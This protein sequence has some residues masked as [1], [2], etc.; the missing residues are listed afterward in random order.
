MK[1]AQPE[2]K[3]EVRQQKAIAMS[4]PKGYTK[5]N[6]YII[7]S[8]EELKIDLNDDHEDYHKA[9]LDKLEDEKSKITNGGSQ[10][11]Q[12][13]KPLPR[14]SRAN[15]LSDEGS[16]DEVKPVAKPRTTQSPG[17]VVTSVNPN[18]VGGYKV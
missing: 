10:P 16:K 1:K 8:K 6:A 12:P 15:S 3:L 4:T 2:L 11:I 14:S 7:Q 5:A 17:A 18:C 9:E 13:P